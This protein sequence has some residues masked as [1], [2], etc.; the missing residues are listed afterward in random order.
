MRP[1]RAI[2]L[3]KQVP[4]LRVGGVGVRADGTIDRAAA[5]PITNPADM[6]AVEA[7]L[8]LA[9][10]VCALSMGPPR[11]DETLRHALAIGASRAVLLCDH[12]LAGSDTWATA[13]ALAAAIEWIGGADLVLCG[14]SAIDGETG[15]VGP[16]VAQRL[17]WPQA[18]ACE[19]LTI[20]GE[21][22]IARRV[23]EG[24][25]ERLR[26]PLPAV[27]TVSETGFS[28]RYPTLPGRRRAA[29][30][31][32]ERV[33]AADVGLGPAQVGLAASPTKVAKMT[34]SPWP[35]RGCR[36]VNDDGFGYD[37]LVRELI[38]RAAFT[39]GERVETTDASTAPEET[40]EGP[41]HDGEASVWV[42]GQ[43]TDGA[44]DRASLE[45]LSK[46]ASLAPALGGGVGA[47]VL[48]A[49]AGA[50]V[51]AA[52]RYGADVV[53]LAEDP[54]L[55]NYLA[56]PYARVIADAIRV[57]APEAVL[58]AATTTGRDLA[59]RIASMLDTGLAA[60][61]TDLY[62][63]SWSRL[64]TTYDGLLHMVR[65]AMAGGVLATCLCPE[66]RPQMAT[67]RPGVFGLRDAPRRPR[68]ERLDVSL[69]ATDLRVEV[70]ERRIS[71]AD[72]DLRDADVVIAGGA[73]CDAASWHL[74]EEL[75]Q[76]IGGRVAAS[77]GA[78]E[79]GLAER[80]QQV[81]QT[82]A[83]VHPRLYV[84][85]GISGALQHAVGMQDSATIVAINRDPNAVV[86]R[87][88]HFGIVADVADAI[89]D[90]VAALQR[91]RAAG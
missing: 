53:Y 30:A 3:V 80:A 9:D 28:P 84:A 5:S 21:S 22:L 23:V 76:A 69:S 32:I 43:M 14:I 48:S 56:E 51:G 54:A 29:S 33:G 62:V 52:G 70:V 8:Q 65:P 75:A 36:Y 83:T 46:A 18:T 82:G 11:A 77:R 91:G 78:V 59:P 17:G 72:V 61:C 24:G 45:L 49:D 67:V 7:A 55:A 79:A 12:V 86:F 16:S 68:V 38:A 39:R 27:V 50:A 15:Q 25:Y 58:F 40:S 64:G 41:G 26:L 37:D 1:L 81:G 4:D 60:D 63:D 34:P 35:D 74:V 2:V 47:V 87:L 31:L 20:D 6:H 44:L 89:P 73:G 85:C 66:A 88:A 10:D 90:L 13:N 42:V 71:N 57:R 19:S